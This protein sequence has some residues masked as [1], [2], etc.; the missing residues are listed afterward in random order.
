MGSSAKCFYKNL[1]SLCHHLIQQ[2]GRYQ[3]DNSDLHINDA[4]AHCATRGG[5]SF[6]LEIDLL[7]QRSRPI[8]CPRPRDGRG[9][10]R[11]VVDGLRVDD[12]L[13]GG[14]VVLHGH[15]GVEVVLADHVDVGRGRVGSQEGVVARRGGVAGLGGQDRVVLP[16]RKGKR[17][18]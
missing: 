16:A 2:G 4:R 6:F 13:L 7:A 12:V 8:D 11:G 1:Q 18:K 3:F 10:H 5:L 17:N 14:E 9:V 15:V